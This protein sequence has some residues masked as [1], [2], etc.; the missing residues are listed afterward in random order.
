MTAT[1]PPRRLPARVR[2]AFG[3]GSIA[4]GIKDNG[5]AT[6]LLLFYNQVLGVPASIVSTVKLSCVLRCANC[7]F[8]IFSDGAIINF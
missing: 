5:F 8:V 3:L 7:A 4:Y 6:F 1:P 2:L